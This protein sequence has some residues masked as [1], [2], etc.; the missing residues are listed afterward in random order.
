MRDIEA[1]HYDWIESVG[2]RIAND[3]KASRYKAWVDRTNKAIARWNAAIRATNGP[4]PGEDRAAY[5]ARLVAANRP[6][7][8]RHKARSGAG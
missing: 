6:T 8:T 2:R 1:E 3:M 7:E 4:R 5:E